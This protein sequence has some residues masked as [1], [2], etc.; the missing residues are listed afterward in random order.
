[1][2]FFNIFKVLIEMKQNQVVHVSR[3]NYFQ[4][5]HFPTQVKKNDFGIVDQ[6]IVSLHYLI[7]QKTEAA[8][9]LMN[10]DNLKYDIFR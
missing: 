4:K 9:I 2:K 1:M 6:Q 10:E 5:Y 7:Y 3:K 8:R